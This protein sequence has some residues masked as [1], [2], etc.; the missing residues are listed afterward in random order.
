[1]SFF[2]KKKYIYEKSY[3]NN[4][5]KIMKKMDLLE[6]IKMSLLNFNFVMIYIIHKMLAFL[7]NRQNYFKDSIF[8]CFFKE[9]NRLFISFKKKFFFTT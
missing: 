1:M 2:L 8:E 6:N 4:Y 7:K 3:K 9:Y 5:Q